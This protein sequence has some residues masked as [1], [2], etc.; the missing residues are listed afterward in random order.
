MG[1]VMDPHQAWL[2]IRGIR[3][4]PVRVRQHGESARKVARYLENHPKIKRVY[5]PGSE[6]YGQKALFAKYLTGTNGLISFVPAG[7]AQQVINFINGLHMFQRGVSWGGFESLICPI[8]TS[9]EAERY[10]VPKNLVRIHVGF[11]DVNTLIADLEKGLAAL[12]DA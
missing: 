10:G 9:E 6:T 8:A 4:L 1:A 7:D 12:P 3:T 2:L 5:Y 11:E